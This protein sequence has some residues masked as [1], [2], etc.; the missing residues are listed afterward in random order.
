M[1]DSKE[2]EACKGCPGRFTYILKHLAQAEECKKSYSDE[3]IVEIRKISKENTLQNKAYKQKK[4]Y[5]S[6]KRAKRYQSQKNIIAKKYDP[7][8]RAEKYKADKQMLMVHRNK[9]NEEKVLPKKSIKI[10]KEDALEKH[11]TLKQNTRKRFKDSKALFHLKHNE[12]NLLK[13]QAKRIALKL[14]DEIEDVGLRA[15]HLKFDFIN[16]SNLFK[17]LMKR[18]ENQWNDINDK[19]SNIVESVP[20]NV[21]CVNKE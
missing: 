9:G 3:E 21:K 4:D 5:D 7:S 2:T 12:L 6:T 8:K 20:L 18:I 14:D 17:T 15:K 19:I 16:V 1:G 13:E 10:L 11:L